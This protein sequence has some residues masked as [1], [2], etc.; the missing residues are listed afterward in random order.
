M[1]NVDLVE[2]EA[3]TKRA[4]RD[5]VIVGIDTGGTFTDIVVLHPDG[6]ITINKSATTPGIL[7]KACSMPLRLPRSLWG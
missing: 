3:G 6:R 2:G 1:A 4:G 5:G 7:R